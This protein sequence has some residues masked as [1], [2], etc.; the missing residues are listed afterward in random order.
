MGTN[1]APAGSHR[2]NWFDVV[3]DR[4][5]PVPGTHSSSCTVQSVALFVGEECWP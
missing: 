2:T 3:N 5:R 4:I 1:M